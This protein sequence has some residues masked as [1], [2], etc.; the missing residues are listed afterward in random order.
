MKKIYTY[1]ADFTAGLSQK[2][3]FRLLSVFIFFITPEWFRDYRF[4]DNYL[5]TDFA[6]LDRLRVKL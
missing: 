1:N 6:S 2:P 4:V 3:V 5:F